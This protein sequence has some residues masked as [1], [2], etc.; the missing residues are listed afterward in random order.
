MG[1]DIIIIIIIIKSNSCNLRGLW[2]LF[3]SIHVVTSAVVSS[4][5]ARVW[6]LIEGVRHLKS[7]PC[8]KGRKYFGNSLAVAIVAIDQRI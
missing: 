2:K 7:R 5:V 8:I 4:I 6:I 1:W 3:R